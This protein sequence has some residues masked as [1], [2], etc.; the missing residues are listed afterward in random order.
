M[1]I[2]SEINI[3]PWPGKKKNSLVLTDV[4]PEGE[5]SSVGTQGVWGGGG[6]VYLDT[7]EEDGEK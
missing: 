2:R 4:F 5:S 7:S 3:W 6:A 1:F